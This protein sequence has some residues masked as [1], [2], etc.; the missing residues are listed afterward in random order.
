MKRITLTLLLLTIV[1]TL[2]MAQKFAYVDTEYILSRVPTF[3]AA[4]DQL[5]RIAS[6]YQAE[7]EQNFKVLDKMFQDFE[8]EKILLTEE[9]RKKR[10]NDIVEKEKE[11]KDLQMKYFG[12]EGM[13]FKK[14]EEL[15]KPIQ[16]QV[17]NAVKEVATEGGF[18]IIFDSAGSA[19]L[20]YTNPRY[21]KSDD[22]LQKLGY[23]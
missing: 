14:R 17:F 9:M 4:Q 21:D 10:E 8:A 1:A 5:D 20:L 15:V 16:D 19:N 2:S 11:A 18:A 22:V 13:L 23:N 12:R 3:K 6:Q 7:I